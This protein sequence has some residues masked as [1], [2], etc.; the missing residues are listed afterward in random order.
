MNNRKADYLF[1]TPSAL[2][3]IARFFDFAGTYDTYNV[4]ATEA[5]ADAKATYLD[6]ICVGDALRAAYEQA[7]EGHHELLLR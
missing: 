2:S 5:E 3:G 4:S 6:W 1:A 7:L